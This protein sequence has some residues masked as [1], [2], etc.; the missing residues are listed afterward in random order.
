MT[1][2]R[3]VL[4][5]WFGAPDS[6]EFGQRRKVWFKVDPAF[7]ESVRAQFGNDADTAGGGGHDSLADDAEGSLALIVMLDQFPR[8]LFR[9][10]ARAFATDAKALGV[11]RAAVAEGF[12]RQF[13]LVQR[14]FVYLP[15]EHSE[16]LTDQEQSVQ[17]FEALGDADYLDYT[18]RHRDIIQRF[19]RFPHRNAVLGR[20]S[21]PEEKAFLEQ[22]GSSFSG[23]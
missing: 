12:D 5:F 9:G 19:G 10:S 23:Y 21:T 17:L 15:F 18:I 20:A 22:P 13:N 11:A 16:D 1:L 2:T 14:C 4:D 7:D 6:S 3:R 8:N